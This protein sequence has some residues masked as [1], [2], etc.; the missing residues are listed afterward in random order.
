[1]FTSFDGTRPFTT[2][3]HV[4]KLNDL[5]DLEEVDHEHVKLRIFRQNLLGEVK[6]WF[7]ALLVASI[8]CFQK[9]EQL[10]LSKREVKKN[11]L[12]IFSEYESLRRNLGDI[13]QEFTTRFNM[14]YNSIPSEIEPPPYLAFLHYPDGFD[15]ELDYDLRE[16]SLVILEEIHSNDIGVEK[17]ILAKKGKM[18]IERRVGLK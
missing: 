16:R 13:V 14:V 15:V 4:D 10:F 3:Q 1:M 2:Q 18:N 12:Q 8:A 6:K 11:P 5:I 17:N 7:K 9:F